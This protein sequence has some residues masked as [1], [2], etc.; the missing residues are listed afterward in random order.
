M[1][2]A[3]FSLS[4][5]K[6][7]ELAA[8]RVPGVISLAQGI[9]SFSTPEVI[10]QF[11]YERIAAGDCDKYSLTT[12]LSEFREEVALSL[13]KD[14]LRA[15]PDTEIIATAGA[16][17][18]MAA[19][20][21]AFT[22]PG[23]DVLLPSPSYA[24]YRNAVAVARCNA[25]FFTLDED[26]NFDFK[27]EA[28]EAA[29]TRN[30]RVLVYCS[31][32]N[33]TGTLFSE[34]KTR[35]LLGLC[36][37]HNLTVVIDEVYK[38]F[39]YSAVPHFTPAVIPEMR[40]RIVRICSFSK[41]FAMTGWRIGFLHSSRENVERVLKFH[42]ALVTCAPVVSQYAAI[43]A[44]RY[45]DSA[46][47]EFR[48][49]FQRRRDYLIGRLDKL[50]NVLDFQI[51]NAT[52]FAF[53]RIKD[54]VPLSRDSN[55]LAYDI[56]EKAKLALV[57]G[58]AFGPSGESHLRISFGKEIQDIAAGMDRL[59]EYFQVATQSAP[60]QK[61][62]QSGPRSLTRLIA[63]KGLAL[64]ASAYL[65]IR[66]PIVI[67]ISGTHGKTVFKRIISE[68]L[69][70]KFRVR[71]GI[72]SY[73]T[74]IGLPLSVLNIKPPRRMRDQLLLP[75]R[76][77]SRLLGFGAGEDLLVL[78]YGVGNSEDAAKLLKIATPDWLVLSAVS[79]TDPGRR[80]G[81]IEEGLQC[82]AR[83]VPPHK[84]FWNETDGVL[85][86]MATQQ[87]WSPGNSLQQERLKGLLG[88]LNL[89]QEKLN[90]NIVGESAELG[91]CASLLLAQT[92]GVTDSALIKRLFI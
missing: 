15:D 46:R 10:K 36:Q 55:R 24:S 78:E 63:A 5:I 88:T 19:T 48:Q 25:R 60:L 40:E 38:D 49:E 66:K 32:N 13:A 54:T 80:Y 26:Y 92:L 61:Q 64:S 3:H 33:P 17:E 90:L 28:V 27:L 7:M 1:A 45:G 67:G 42:D 14:G 53:P 22:E 72:L 83:A 16:A 84:I 57:P 12:G 20:I 73:N 79:E 91:L 76:I 2:P 71:A 35:E 4:P 77:L 69:S 43:A 39:Y 70:A 89:R 23:D 59:S 44:L 47:E 56:L 34:N 75:F 9:P 37:R 6:A 30:T 50:S 8:S 74:E 51:P 68:V 86:E 31:P 58:A 52:Y 85:K 81:K 82:V 87:G 21:L 62:R 41:A 29:L 11:V 65:K 18:A